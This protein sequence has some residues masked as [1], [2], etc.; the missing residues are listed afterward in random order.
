MAKPPVIRMPGNKR[1]VAD[2]KQA[3]ESDQRYYRGR[4][5]RLR[6]AGSITD[7]QYADALM[8]L[9][10]V[11]TPF[12]MLA[13]RVGFHIIAQMV[14]IPEDVQLCREEQHVMS[15]WRVLD[16]ASGILPVAYAYTTHIRK[17][18]T[19][20]PDPKG[21]GQVYLGCGY[22]SLR[23]MNRAGIIT[24]RRY[25]YRSDYVIEGASGDRSV[26]PANFRVVK[27]MYELQQMIRRAESG[28]EAGI[29]SHPGAIDV[30]EATPHL[31][32]VRNQTA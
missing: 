2:V 19:P 1:L 7:D 31:V 12:V 13:E 8:L 9:N 10:D 20:Y 14:V 17:C 26:G 6:S 28:E 25:D 18:V 24:G 15:P 32:V 30:A 23:G 11:L 27:A 16:E 4:L 3:I 22:Y 29:L 5:S 21:S